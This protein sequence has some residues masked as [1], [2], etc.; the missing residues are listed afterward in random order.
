M[1]PRIAADY[2]A[3][4][5]I[6]MAI[7]LVS[8]PY[9]SYSWLVFYLFPL[10]I[11]FAI[12]AGVI[13]HNHNHCPVFKSW[14]M[15]RL[16]SHVLTFFY[17]YPT[18]VWVAVHNG[19]HHKHVNRAG[20]ASIT[21]RYNNDH[22]AWTAWTFFFVS[23][24]HQGV[25]IKA[26]IQKAKTK[27]PKLYRR[28]V[29]QYVIWLGTWAAVWL[30]GVT[31]YGLR[32]GTVMWLLGVGLPSLMSLWVIMFFNYEQHVHTDPWSEHNHSRNFVG[33]I[34]NFLLF[35]NG[36]HGI[37]HEKPA[38][39]WSK[40]PAAHQQIADKI[41]PELCQTNVAWYFIRQF[42]LAPFW[43]QYGSQQIG[44]APFDTPDGG[45]LDLTAD[46][47]EL[48]EAGSN[49]YMVTARPAAVPVRTNRETPVEA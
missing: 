33:P 27:N 6:G 35:N 15:N 19:N 11:Y 48:G 41:D 2:R 5:W 18:F 30:T 40:L 31:L 1:L 17:G 7:T 13:A 38:L 45:P 14:R 34:V 21:W 24:Y 29:A 26:F 10:N 43:P 32:R 16:F 22:T 42:A 37:H 44:R 47:V 20:D 36:Y 3:L 49:T 9:L 25:P 12:A 23:A 28:I 4:L 46:E 8:I 39:H